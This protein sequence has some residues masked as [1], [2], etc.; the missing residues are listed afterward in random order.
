M[1]GLYS[2]FLGRQALREPSQDRYDHQK[3]GENDCDERLKNPKFTG[4]F[5]RQAN[6]DTGKV[7]GYY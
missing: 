2:K 5:Q 1:D 4:H 6:L 7:A 3:S